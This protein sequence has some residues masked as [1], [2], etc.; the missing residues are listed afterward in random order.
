[1]GAGAGSALLACREKVLCEHPLQL[2]WNWRLLGFAGFQSQK[3]STG[4][5]PSQQQGTVSLLPSAPLLKLNGTEGK[6]E[7]NMEEILAQHQKFYVYFAL[8]PDTAFV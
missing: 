7:R 6:G 3:S 4:C 8:S 5:V 2:P 1:M